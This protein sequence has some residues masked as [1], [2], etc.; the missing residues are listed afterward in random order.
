MIRCDHPGCKFTFF[1]H[2]CVKFNSD[3]PLLGAWYCP[4]CTALMSDGEVANTLQSAAETSTF[5]S[6]NQQP[7]SQ[8]KA[9]S[10]ASSLD[11]QRQHEIDMLRNLSP[12]PN[13]PSDSLNVVM[14]SMTTEESGV[15]N[16][17]EKCRA[18]L[19][20]SPGYATLSDRKR[21]AKFMMTRSEDMVVTE[22]IE[23]S[24][25]DPSSSVSASIN[26]MPEKVS[27]NWEA[28]PVSNPSIM[29][30]RTQTAST[31]LISTIAD[32]HIARTSPTS[33]FSFTTGIAAKSGSLSS[34]TDKEG[35]NN[36]SVLLG[37][38]G[39]GSHDSADE[40]VGMIDKKV[41]GKG[42]G[43]RRDRKD[44]SDTNN[45]Q[46]TSVQM[47]PPFLNAHVEPANPIS[48]PKPPLLA[49]KNPK[50]AQKI[51][52]RSGKSTVSNKHR[53]TGAM[54]PKVTESLKPT[55]G[56]GD[57]IYSASNPAGILPVNVIEQLKGR[58]N[59]EVNGNLGSV[60]QNQG[61]LGAGMTATQY[62]VTGE[63]RDSMKRSFEQVSDDHS[64][65]RARNSDNLHLGE[66]AA[67]GPC[68]LDAYSTTNPPVN[69][70]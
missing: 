18:A 60:E 19:E 21:F 63:T 1:H 31:P 59:E 42:L 53:K 24:W 5:R 48:K 30:P 12:A 14:K 56:E 54:D 39:L 3:S 55:N 51:N 47:Q 41:K 62:S 69:L 29:V 27:S 67:A 7:V 33:K 40:T 2:E 38:S 34:C 65:K 22:D 35:G 45:K 61:S 46:P 50:V 49:M 16:V 4:D 52:G 11:R 9:S 17:T 44:K 32:A 58:G 43:T 10:V 66:N 20:A 6:P 57:S 36:M 8:L 23:M 26:T 13:T 15:N 70:T 37:G 28:G 25:V 64:R 68:A